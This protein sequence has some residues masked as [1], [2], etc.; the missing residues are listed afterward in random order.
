MDIVSQVA[1]ISFLIVCGGG[2]I[3]GIFLIWEFIRWI[4]DLFD[5]GS[6]KYEHKRRR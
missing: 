4:D 2:F 6:D 5:D 3:L 1:L